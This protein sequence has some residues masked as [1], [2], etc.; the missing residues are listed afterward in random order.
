MSYFL[1]PLSYLST[2]AVCMCTNRKGERQP[3]KEEEEREGLAA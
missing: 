2:L 3:E 1:G